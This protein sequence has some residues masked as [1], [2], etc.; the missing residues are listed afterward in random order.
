VPVRP[1]LPARASPVAVAV[2]TTKQ[3]PAF[4]SGRLTAVHAIQAQRD[5]SR[6]RAIE[7]GPRQAAQ[8]Y[9]REVRSLKHAKMAASTRLTRQNPASPQADLGT[10]RLRYTGAFTSSPFYAPFQKSWN[11]RRSFGA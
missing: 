9:G 1:V 7:A 6:V 3:A 5:K 2:R 8:A 10:G 11:S 4:A